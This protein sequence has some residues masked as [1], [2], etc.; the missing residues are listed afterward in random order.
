[1]A[2][3]GWL[4]ALCLGALAAGTAHAGP[5]LEQVQRRGEVRCGVTQGLPGFSAPDARGDWQG[6]DADYCR[7]IATLSASSAV[8]SRS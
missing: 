8:T 2:S 3:R 5:T 7:A 6:I 1:M 4:L